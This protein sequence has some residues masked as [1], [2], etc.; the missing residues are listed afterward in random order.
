VRPSCPA[1]SGEGP[2]HSTTS[3]IPSGT[4]AFTHNNH[5]TQCGVEHTTYAT[6]QCDICDTCDISNMCQTT[7]GPRLVGRESWAMI[8]GDS[9]SD[10]PNDPSIGSLACNGTLPHQTGATSPQL[11][12][13]LLA[14]TPTIANHSPRTRKRSASTP[15][16][17]PSPLAESVQSAVLSSNVGCASAFSNP[18]VIA[19]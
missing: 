12:P 2:R 18:P 13:V 16:G 8:H 17:A 14:A 7:H 1:H 3:S 19:E 4:L 15:A 6:W 9:P 10:D 11:V 5:V